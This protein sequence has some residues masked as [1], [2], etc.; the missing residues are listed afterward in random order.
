MAEIPLH[1]IGGNLR[2]LRS[3]LLSACSFDTQDEESSIVQ[4]K[5]MLA[6]HS[7]F[8]VPLSMH[9]D[10]NTG[11]NHEELNAIRNLNRTAKAE[12]ALWL[13]AKFE[14]GVARERYVAT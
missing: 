11:L 10:R 5:E 12:L 13:K 9:A 14:E 7:A 8:S 3:T 1:S 2:N 6:S 4:T